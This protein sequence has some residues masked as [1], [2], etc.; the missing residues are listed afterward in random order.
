MASTIQQPP[1]V[2]TLLG[3]EGLLSDDDNEGVSLLHDDLEEEEEVGRREVNP[4]HGESLSDPLLA[5]S[6][7]S[8][9]LPTQHDPKPDDLYSKVE[10]NGAGAGAGGS[11][12]AS[13]DDWRR[14]GNRRRRDL[15][16][17]SEPRRFWQLFVGVLCCFAVSSSYAFNLYSGQ[18][19]SKYN[20]T[21]SQMT[22]ITT[23]AD[24]VGAVILIF[25]FLYD[26]YGAW[27]LFLTTMIT[28][29][30]GAVLFG[31]T[32]ANAI[33]GSVPAFSVYVS[34]LA[35][36]TS[37]LD[38]CGVMTLLSIFPVNR[39]A[40]VAVMKTFSG[41]GSAILGAIH[42]AFFSEN[43]DSDTSRFFFFVAAVASVVSFLGLVFVEVPPY[44]IK[45]C[46]QNVLTDEERRLRRRLKRQYLRQK[47]PAARFAV[48]VTIVLI[49]VVFL[50]TQGALSAYFDLD[51]KYHVAFA[52]IAIGL[53]ALYPIMALPLKIFD[54]KV[55]LLDAG[56]IP[57]TSN[58]VSR[59][60]RFTRDSMNSAADAADI[61][62]IAPQ[63]Q[64]TAVENF[65]TFRFL[66]LVW[67]LFC[68]FGAHF[69]ILTNMR[70]LVGALAGK[71]LDESFM[72]LLVVLVGVGS[73]VG[74][75][76][77]SI[78]EMATQGKPAERRMPITFILFVPTGFTVLTLVLIMLVTPKAL[79]IPCFI[80]ALASGCTAA[81]VVIVLRTIYAKDVAKHYNF[82]MVA[83]IVASVVM[84][85]LVY[86]E[87]YTHQAAKQG[88]SLC[89][90]KQCVLM[91]LLVSL[92]MN[93]SAV[94]STVYIHWDYSRYCRE[95][96]ELRDDRLRGGRRRSVF[97][98]SV[99]TESVNPMD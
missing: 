16:P 92:G 93:I 5:P 28:F 37:L 80:M 98:D 3:P 61:D 47:A 66:L 79:P 99:L 50:P 62:F 41:M 35:L 72:A 51:H 6:I 43:N 38:I 59:A 34:L 68:L 74:R 21:Q 73:G 88:G 58:R 53:L 45:G 52:C 24:V 75:I 9:L 26:R 31:L 76:L 91:P 71:P 77:L 81:A 17:L 90:G 23:V 97:E 15:P 10:Q 86:G 20:F 27:P 83:G 49:L 1:F 78:F 84:N 63:Y 2:H 70:F 64:T 57:C 39:G 29:S 30:L 19:Q 13:G 36:G 42:L 55:N 69:I 14:S 4:A 44:M 33:T 65:R 56:S 96:L 82:C 85:R 22:T 60:S 67:T 46:E 32:Y 18:L 7:A 87:W 48:G 8:S 12:A 89:Y 40:V 94:A 54:R 95:M 25:G 11:S